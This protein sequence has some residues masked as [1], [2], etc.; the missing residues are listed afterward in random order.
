MTIAT[1]PSF[2][3]TKVVNGDVC[4]VQSGRTWAQ[5]KHLQRGFE[6]ARGVQLFYWDGTVEILMPGKLQE[7]F[8]SVIGLLI[9]V[10]LIDRGIEFEP[11]GSMTQEVE[12]VASADADASYRIGDHRLAVEVNFTS[13]SAAKLR[14]YQA[15]GVDEVWLWEDGVLQAYH[16]R[17][18]GYEAVSQSLI[19]E[20]ATIDLAVLSACILA[21]EMSRVAAVRQFRAAHKLT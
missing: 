16:L 10:F 3:I 13:G 15:L 14:R 1:E 21:G 9:E 8:K 6:H 20:L 18:D 5:F 12:A 11:T 7:L 4:T 2:S 19:P 17:A